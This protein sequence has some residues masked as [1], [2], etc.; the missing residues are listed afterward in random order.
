MTMISSM[1]KGSAYIILP[2]LIVRAPR[3]RRLIINS[4]RF[5]VVGHF[6]LNTL[7]FFANYFAHR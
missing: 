7:V 2:D 6:A 5:L 1:R 4:G 3:R